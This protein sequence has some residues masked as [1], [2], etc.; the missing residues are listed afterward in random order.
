MQIRFSSKSLE[1]K[2]TNPDK[3]VKAFG[4]M[5]KKVN[6]R[7]EELKAAVNLED[8]GK[9]PAAN[10]H[11][12]GSNL[13]GCYAVDISV[14][15]RIIFKPDHDPIPLKVDGGMDRILITDIEV[16]DVEDYH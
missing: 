4:T 8:M 6:Q 11:L 13:K 14:N 1:K 15:F 9:L 2:L 3:M 16:L 12:L 7:M 5:A 10:C